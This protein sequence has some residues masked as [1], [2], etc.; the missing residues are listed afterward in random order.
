M[1][2]PRY[3]NHIITLSLVS[4]IN[5]VIL[6]SVIVWHIHSAVV[7]ERKDLI[8]SQV[9]SALGLAN[10]IFQKSL[11]DGASS[12]EAEQEL[13]KYIG[14]MTFQENGYFWVLDRQGKMLAHPNLANMSTKSLIDVQDSEGRFFIRDMLNTADQGGGFVHYEWPKPG[15]RQPVAKIGY[16]ELFK[17]WQ[18][19]FVSGLYVDDLNQD[20]MEQFSLG[21][22]IIFVLFVLSIFVSLR[23]S[24]GY[25][26]EFRHKATH[27]SLTLLYSRG[28]LND[29]APRM[30]DKAAKTPFSIVFFDLDKFKSIND[31]LGHKY[32]DSVLSEASMIIKSALL[33]HKN[34]FRYG[35]EE[36]V[37]LL[38]ATEEESFD[39]AEKVR[40]AIAE[41]E[42]H[43]PKGKPFHITVS[44]G[45]AQKKAGDSLV[46]LLKRADLCMYIAKE[47]GRNKVVMDSDV[48]KA[49]RD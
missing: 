34:V 28:H 10:K 25:L 7:K 32:G 1:R 35:G 2:Q 18:L 20:I 15:G 31:E 40:L 46:E 30:F 47:R 11:A 37:A 23:L 42:F 39:I 8:H 48:R 27:D 36:L 9:E 4:V 33:P 24:K 5:M 14:A 38:K 16:V 44:A 29:V 13:F 12:A 17:P 6:L 19:V 45:I 26:K 43:G 21:F 41:H 3:Q 49:D 22:V